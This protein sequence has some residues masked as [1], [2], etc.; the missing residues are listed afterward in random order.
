MFEY[1]VLVP[2]LDDCYV[3]ISLSPKVIIL[4][5]QADRE[6]EWLLTRPFV[7]LPDNYLRQGHCLV[8]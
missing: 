4:L 6:R 8:P 7:A 5:G 3:N 1:R 2:V